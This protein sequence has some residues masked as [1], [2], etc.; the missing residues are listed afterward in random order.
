MTGQADQAQPDLDVRQ[1]LNENLAHRASQ[2]VRYPPHAVVDAVAGPGL[3]APFD[4]GWSEVDHD[5]P[6]G[7]TKWKCTVATEEHLGRVSLFA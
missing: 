2:V 3:P 7:I 1:W 4:I 5:V 6:T